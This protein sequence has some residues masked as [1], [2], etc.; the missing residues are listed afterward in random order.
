MKWVIGTH[1]KGRLSKLDDKLDK[2]IDP[3]EIE[4]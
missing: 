3:I 1:L 2:T 4:N